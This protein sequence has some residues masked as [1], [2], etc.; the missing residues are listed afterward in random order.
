[1]HSSNGAPGGGGAPFSGGGGTG[2]PIA[3]SVFKMK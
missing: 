2:A 1:M 3:D